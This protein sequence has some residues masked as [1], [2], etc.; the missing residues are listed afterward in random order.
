MIKHIVLFLAFLARVHA[1]CQHDEAAVAHL[2]EFAYARHVG[3]QDA[4]AD[5]LELALF[6]AEC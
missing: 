6:E 3:D 4:M 2:Q 5:E 1:A